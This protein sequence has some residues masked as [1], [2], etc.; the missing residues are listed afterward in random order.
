MQF[1]SI[2]KSQ[3][4]ITKMARVDYPSVTD[5]QVAI[6]I[7]LFNKGESHRSIALQ[8]GINESII[9]DIL[10]KHKVVKSKKDKW[11]STLTSVQEEALVKFLIKSST[12]QGSFRAFKSLLE[13]WALDHRWACN[14]NF[15]WRRSFLKRHQLRLPDNIKKYLMVRPK[16]EGL[17]VAHMVVQPTDVEEEMVDEGPAEDDSVEWRIVADEQAQPGGGLS[18]QTGST[19][20][21]EEAEQEVVHQEIHLTEDEKAE[22]AQAVQ[23][24]MVVFSR[25]GVSDE[26]AQR[27]LRNMSVPGFGPPDKPKPRSQRKKLPG[28]NRINWAESWRITSTTP[29]TLT[30]VNYE[31]PRLPA[32]KTPLQLRVLEREFVKNH[33]PTHLQS[34]ALAKKLSLPH[35][36]VLSWF[37]NRR[38]K[39]TKKKP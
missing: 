28:F 38:Q 23:M 15:S 39:S 26:R 30:T 37:R 5:E 29:A 31:P 8:L 18:Q 3:D 22:L 14:I 4:C 7:A 11:A 21:E 12:F 25:A 36:A 2:L 27:L 35:E 20:D 13:K 34:E 33:H 17:D 19:E 24:A 32:K 6:M 9:R 1:Q 10:K 16:E